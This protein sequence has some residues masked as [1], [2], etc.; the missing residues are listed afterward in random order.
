VAIGS[1]EYA[2]QIRDF[3]VLFDVTSF[4]VGFWVLNKATAY[5]LQH[6]FKHNTSEDVVPGY[7][8]PGPVDCI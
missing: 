6:I 3:A 4:Y 2:P 5:K 1:E 7:E 8:V